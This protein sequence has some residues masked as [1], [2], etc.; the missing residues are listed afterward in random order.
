MSQMTAVNVIR[1]EKGKGAEVAERFAIPK[2][3]HTFPGFVRME[4][5]LKE[6]TEVHD[7]LHVC[8]TWEDEKYFTEWRQKRAIEKAKIRAEQEKNQTGTPPHNP[9]LGTELSTYVT[10]VQH[11][12]SK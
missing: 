12:P 1:I 4:V 9:I 3:V 7:E 11:L 6:D 8:T 10:M 5:W 2:S